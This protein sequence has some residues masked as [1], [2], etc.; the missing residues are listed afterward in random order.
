MCSESNVYP[1]HLSSST[2]VEVCAI[3]SHSNHT[4]E[5]YHMSSST[6]QE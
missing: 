5:T 3:R 6:E 2:K 4:T 1:E